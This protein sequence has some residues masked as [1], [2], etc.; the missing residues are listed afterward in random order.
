MTDPS[1]LVVRDLVVAFPAAE[2]RAY[3]TARVSL[4]IAARE[5]VG[6]VG[7]SGSG[8]SITA[9]AMLGMA[10]PPGRIVG[11]SVTWRG[12]SLLDPRV[13]RDVRGREIA[14]VFQDPSSSLNPL[15]PIGD[16]VDEILM[17][18]KGLDGRRARRRT[19]ELLSSVGIAR[20]AER[21]RQLPHEF[22]GGMR[23]RAMIAVA[24][25]S[26]PSLLIADEP[27]TALD[28]TVQAQILDLLR[29]LS[30][31][32]QF[33]VL[34]ISHDL[35]VIGEF[36]ERVEVMYAGRIVE[37]APVENM[38]ERAA[39]PYTSALLALS[40]RVDV[41]QPPHVPIPGEPAIPDALIE[42]CAF[43][44]RCPEARDLCRAR[45]PVL[46]SWIDAQH[47]VACWNR[48]TS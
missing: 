35:A 20:A 29:D 42:S 10:P 47:E 17:Q 36:C 30:A 31:E 38:F 2:G 11:G 45:R 48:T 6:L 8:K 39:H 18:R 3:G 23:Q 16:H 22:S 13:A 25:A 9:L 1:L 24:L 19:V 7:E 28:V 14:I 26:N 4:E 5:R 15:K 37:R 43:A 33:A 12:R 44:P 46:A 34:L 27:T 41:D 32:L 21:S 40:P